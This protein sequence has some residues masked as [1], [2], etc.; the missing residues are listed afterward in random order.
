MLRRLILGSLVLVCGLLAL[1][2]LALL[3][4][5]APIASQ[6]FDPGPRPALG[7]LSDSWSQTCV[8]YARREVP[9]PE[10]LE[11]DA[12]GRVYAGTH[13]GKVVRLSA[14]PAASFVL[15]DLAKPGGRPNGITLDGAGR[16]LASQG[17]G[18][19]GDRIWPDGRVEPLAW[20]DG[21]DSAVGRDGTVYFSAPQPWRRTGHVGVDFGLLM[22]ESRPDGELRAWRPDTGRVE[23]LAR[24]LLIPDGVALSANEDFVAVGEV[25]GF[26][27]TRYWLRGPKAGTADVLIGSLPGIPDGLASD[28]EGTFYVALPVR[29]GALADALHRSA[30]AKDQVAKLLA[31]L[32][33][34]LLRDE[35]TD[36]TGLGVVLAVD[37]SGRVTRTYLEPRGLVGAAITTAVPHGDGLW[38]GSLLGHGVARCAR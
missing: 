10:E 5:P 8:V 24:G 33:P 28:G 23:V 2:A 37:E 21:G 20:L 14:G 30:F 4:T 18:R 22:L 32:G 13:E 12:Q 25:S 11:V 16:I 27:V 9:A 3:L 36:R 35:P 15:E 38:I 17:Y 31:R 29:R 26:R 6:P 1:L 7:P 19:T 34:R